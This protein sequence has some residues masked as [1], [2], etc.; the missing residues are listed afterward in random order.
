[1]IRNLYLLWPHPGL[2][3]RLGI[4][5]AIMAI[6]QGLLLGALV[7]ILRALLSPDPDFATAAP[8]LAAAGTGLMVYGILS[9]ISTPF[10][11][12]ASMDLAAQLRRHLM[13]HVTTLPLGWFTAERKARLSVVRTF[14]A[15]RGVN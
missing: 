2:L 4:L 3:M 15:D 11:F 13:R 8:W 12:A 10:G 1:M 9:I 14:G 7:P 6:L 5:T